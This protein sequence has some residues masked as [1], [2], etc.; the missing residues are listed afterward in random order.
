VIRIISLY[1]LVLLAL[2]KE[3]LC[4]QVSVFQ[5][6]TVKDG[7]PSNF[8]F[9]ASEDENGFLWIGTDKGL[10]KYDGFTWQII[11]TDMGLPGNYINYL[12]CDG[13]GGIWLAIGQKGMYYYNIAKKQF[14]YITKEGGLDGHN[15]NEEG[16]LFMLSYEQPKNAFSVWGYTMQ[17]KVKSRLIYEMPFTGCDTCKLNI[18]VDIKNKKII[19][20]ANVRNYKNPANWIIEKK[21][22]FKKH[23]LW[24]EKSDS[25]Y[26]LDGETYL[27]RKDKI[28]TKRIFTKKG[29]FYF[30]NV[31]SQFL[32]CNIND[33]FWQYDIEGNYKNYTTKD[34]LASNLVNKILVTKKK[35]FFICTL[36]GGLQLLLPAK[37]AKINTNEKQVRAIAVDKNIAY[38]CTENKLLVIDLLKLNI[39]ESFPLSETTIESIAVKDGEIVIGSITGI[40]I[41]K[42]NNHQL[43]K[44]NSIKEGAGISTV[45]TK[46]KNYLS[47]TYGSGL[48]AFDKQNKPIVIN[49]LAKYTIIE[50][51]QQLKNGYAALTYED[52]LHFFNNKIEPQ[53]TITTKDGLLSNEVYDVHE[54]KDSFWVSTAKG[55]SVYANN[56]VVKNIS[57]PNETSKNKCLY[58]FHDNAGKYWVVTNK[59]LHEY[60]NEKLFTVGTNPL[61][62]NE[63]ENIKNALYD[64]ATNTLIAGT[65]S[66]ISLLNMSSVVRDTNVVAPALLFARA[67]NIDKDF[68]QSFSLSH[69]FNSIYFSFIPGISNPFSQTTIQYK[70]VGFNES[71]QTLKD[72]TIISFAKLRPGS[73]TLLAKTINVDSYESKEIELANFE[74]EKPIWLRAW[75]IILAA[76]ATV[77][78]S[79][80]LFNYF[81]RKKQLQKDKAN[82]LALSVSKE[83]ERIS[84][85][86]HDHLGT[87][88]V[89]MIVQTD[90]IE[91]KLINNNV[92][93]AL[94]KVQ[95]LSDQSRESMNVLRETI[96]AVQENSHTLS[97]FTLRVRT[98]LQRVMDAHE[99]NWALE[100]NGTLQK[101]LSAEQTLHLFRMIQEVTQNIIKHA[102][103]KKANYSIDANI[104]TF[105]I[106]ITD[107]GK[108]FDTNS[109][110]TS[111]GLKN[112]AARIKELDGTIEIKSVLQKGTSII[113]QLSI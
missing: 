109:I 81:Q 69:D 30:T 102:G 77:L 46:D 105:K 70:L 54:Y 110:Y 111:N 18:D 79:F 48:K 33:G 1:F 63:K 95:Q 86:L 60:S 4:Q 56:K 65:S 113:V 9:D 2:P 31:G 78:A 100:C 83:R 103:A 107:D 5:T 99:M 20:F 16:E 28:F 64:V 112:L 53:K 39:I 85:D 3:T 44:I 8:V 15:M 57:L 80:L 58:S 71:F 40:N 43:V 88:L 108:G 23:L 7:L 52:G 97:E 90:N 94:L 47:S 38:S 29:Y 25:L 84:K 76:I 51:L 68:K 104:N 11:N 49:D 26:F 37:N 13:R 10:A 21:V 73:Y 74:I 14:T 72:S 93:D 34:G 19:Q 36:G 66:E 91:N 67:D 32:S 89:T 61:L 35:Q 101:D 45:F 75:F 50:K 92:A 41:Y 6:L 27:H 82:Q 96:W 59:A 24:S 17:E 98:F 87:S 106:S 55:I 12:S 22:G 62:N 42:I